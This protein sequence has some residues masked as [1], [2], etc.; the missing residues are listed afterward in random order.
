MRTLEAFT[1][2]FASSMWDR[3]GS[4][5]Y[6]HLVTTAELTKHAKNKQPLVVD[7]EFV[8]GSFK[9]VDSVLHT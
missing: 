2:R 3:G 7:E 6:E 5:A 4:P 9:L 8:D 1:A